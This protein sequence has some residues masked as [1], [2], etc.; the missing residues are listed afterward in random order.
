MFF[1]TESLF[2][3]SGDYLD[4]MANFNMWGMIIT[5]ITLLLQ[6]RSTNYEI[7]KQQY[8]DSGKN[9]EEVTTKYPS[10]NW[11]KRSGLM[12]LEISFGINFVTFVGFWIIIFP[13][14]G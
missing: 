1:I 2:L 7:L 13:N 4:L 11:Y 6:Y 5:F 12:T 9:D 14:T 10:S 8:I 3:E